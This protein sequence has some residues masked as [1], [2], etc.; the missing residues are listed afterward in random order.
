MPYKVSDNVLVLIWTFPVLGNHLEV[1]E[2]SLVIGDKYDFVTKVQIFI[3]V[4]QKKNFEPKIEIS[5]GLGFKCFII[6][7]GKLQITK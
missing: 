6:H 7:G 2:S 1:A 4:G 3:Y 5:N